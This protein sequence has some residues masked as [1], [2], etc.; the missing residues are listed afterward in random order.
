MSSSS[1]S[2]GSVQTTGRLEDSPPTGCPDP[3]PIGG[4]SATATP[5]ES[6]NGSAVPAG[7]AGPAATATAPLAAPAP[8]AD[9]ANVALIGAVLGSGTGI[10]APPR[11]EPAG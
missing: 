9:E 2:A 7:P 5:P 8:A 10:D 6:P 1:V 3:S 4:R 11:E